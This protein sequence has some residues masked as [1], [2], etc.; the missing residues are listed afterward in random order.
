MKL[1]GIYRSSNLLSAL[2]LVLVVLMA[3][4]LLQNYLASSGNS[5]QKARDAIRISDIGDIHQA[6]R[7]HNAQYGVYPAC[8][9]KEDCSKSLEAS[10]IMPEVPKD[11]LTHLKYSYAAFGASCHG[12]H[13]GASLERTGSQAL[14]T[15]ADAQAQPDS[16]L[17]QGSQPDFS[18]LSYAPGGQP[19]DAKP[20]IPEPS[21]EPTAETCYD[22]AR[23]INTPAATR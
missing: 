4:L 15:G 22:L 8:L 11:P 5:I 1:K 14:L 12:Y 17:C 18:G 3:A 13:L 21:D 7:D 16:A 19:C 9:Y 10:A 2:L 20:G 6:I 23:V